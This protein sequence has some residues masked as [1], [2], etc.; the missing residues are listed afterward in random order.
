[1][2]REVVATICLTEKSG[3]A[4]MVV[5]LFASEDDVASLAGGILGEDVGIDGGHS[6][7]S[8]NC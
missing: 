8:V 7:H 3:S 2:D 6:T 5:A 4:G 1:M